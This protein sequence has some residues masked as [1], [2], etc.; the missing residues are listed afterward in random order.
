MLFGDPANGGLI[1]GA[2]QHNPRGIQ[3]DF[4][5]VVSGQRWLSVLVWLQSGWDN[6]LQTAVFSLSNS[7][8]YSWGAIPG[9]GFGFHNDGTGLRLAA[10]NGAAPV[11]QAATIAPQQKWLLVVARTVVNPDGAD[12]ISLWAFDADATFGVTESSLGEPH[13]HHEGFNWGSGFHNLWIG[14]SRPNGPN[15][16]FE[17]DELRVSTEGGDRGL[18]QILAE[19]DSGIQIGPQVAIDA[20]GT[21]EP[22][23]A[24]SLVA[25]VDDPDNHPGPVTLQWFTASGPANAFFGDTAGATTEATFPVAGTYVLRLI[26]DDGA[27]S[28]FADRSLDAGASGETGFATWMNTYAADIPADRRGPLDDASGDALANLLAYARGLDPRQAQH[29]PDRE[30]LRVARDGNDLV[31]TLWIPEG[32]DRPD[33]VYRVLQSADLQTWSPV[34]EAAGST[35]FTPV[36]ENAPAITREA[37]ALHLRLPATQAYFRLEVTF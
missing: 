27:V 13:V 35:A 24:I 10:L 5:E 20:P 34:A 16:V 3:R 12:V 6:A 1:R 8:S 25:Q 22:G 29:G 36:G 11:A 26:A 37:D 17:F 15:A 31:V 28:T 14:A 23:H 7:S 21:A 18:G 32:L 30:T 4:P 33:L 19:L 9:Q 2:V